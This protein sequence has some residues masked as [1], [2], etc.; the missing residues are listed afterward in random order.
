MNHED[1]PIKDQM[2]WI[3]ILEHPKRNLEFYFC[4]FFLSLFE[5][6]GGSGAKISDFGSIL[7]N[8]HPYGRF[9]AWLRNSLIHKLCP[10]K[11]H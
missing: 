3:R 5:W 1:L 7:S 4:F 9:K 10:H 8:N 11:L 6:N 2:A